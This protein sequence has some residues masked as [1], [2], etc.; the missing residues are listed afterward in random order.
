MA[1]AAASGVTQPCRRKR[2][3]EP[4]EKQRARGLKGERMS[5]AAAAVA[6][7]LFGPSGAHPYG[8]SPGPFLFTHLFYK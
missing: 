1:A 2:G 3:E 4:G 6:Q 7:A 5:D 8:T